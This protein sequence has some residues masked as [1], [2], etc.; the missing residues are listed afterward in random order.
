MGLFVDMEDPEQMMMGMEENLDDTDLEAEFAAIT[1]AKSA[2]GG[3][4]RAK[5]KGKSECR[6]LL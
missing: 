5:P 3:G 2:G 4:G 6:S 1:G